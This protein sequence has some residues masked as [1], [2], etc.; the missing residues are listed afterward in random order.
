MYS[1]CKNDP[2]LILDWD[3]NLHAV[4]VQG[5]RQLLAVTAG[6]TGQKS[7]PSDQNSVDT[8]E[9]T[10]FITPCC[11]HVDLDKFLH[12]FGIGLKL[13]LEAFLQI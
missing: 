1:H 13:D 3:G 2:S 5:R 9:L 12:I 10:L 8:L 4:V 7:A 11:C 6:K